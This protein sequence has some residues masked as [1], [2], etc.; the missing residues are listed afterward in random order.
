MSSNFMIKKTFFENFPFT[1][2]HQSSGISCKLYIKTLFQAYPSQIIKRYQSVIR[3]LKT[4]FCVFLPLKGVLKRATENNFVNALI[5]FIGVK[6][7]Y[8]ITIIIT[9]LIILLR[10]FM[11]VMAHGSLCRSRHF[12]VTVIFERRL[13]GISLFFHI[14]EVRNPQVF[15]FP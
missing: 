4:I 8:E 3:K 7:R 12:N 5:L 10:L 11:P 14:T 1:L 2:K 6:S 15:S 13:S 9:F